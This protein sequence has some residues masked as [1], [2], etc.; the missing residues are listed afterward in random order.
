MDEARVSQAPDK[1]QGPS[2]TG[3]LPSAEPGA[4][5]R[6][7]DAGPRSD[8]EIARIAREAVEQALATMD[9]PEIRRLARATAPPR[10]SRAERTLMGTSIYGRRVLELERRRPT[11]VRL[12]GRAPQL[13]ELERRR[14]TRARSSISERSRPAGRA[15]RR[16]ATRR[17]AASDSIGGGADPPG[18][19]G[20]PPF[21]SDDPDDALGVAPPG[22]GDSQ[23]PGYPPGRPHV[24][25]RPGGT[26]LRGMR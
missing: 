14:A 22:L 4:P 20:D 16:A 3:T 21:K 25:P 10:R 6:L 26:S 11:R 8:A 15:P 17:R 23:P 19:S 1:R 9:D 5:A 18:P 2:E 12:A 13:L 7:R 24:V